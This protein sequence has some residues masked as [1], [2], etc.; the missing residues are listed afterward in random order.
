MKLKANFFEEK[1]IIMSLGMRDSTLI[2]YPGMSEELSKLLIIGPGEALNTNM[3]T[4]S[5]KKSI[6]QEIQSQVL[7]IACNLF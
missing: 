2:N 3:R 5:K 4:D 6:L 7:L 1:T